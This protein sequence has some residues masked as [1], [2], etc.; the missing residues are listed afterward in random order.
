MDES[1]GTIGQQ[2]GHLF[3]F[4]YSHTMKAFLFGNFEEQLCFD[5]LSDDEVIEVL[6]EIN[7]SLGTNTKASFSQVDLKEDS[8]SCE[9]SSL[10]S[11]EKSKVTSIMIVKSPEDLEFKGK[12]WSSRCL[13]NECESQNYYALSGT[14][15]NRTYND[16]SSSVRIAKPSCAGQ[17]FLII[18]A[19][20]LRYATSSVLDFDGED[21]RLQ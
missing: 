2:P 18:H 14:V 12:K 1:V 10:T 13:Y 8:K 19:S 7:L 6:N 9:P 20:P 4:P 15:H 3:L 16:S 21:F 17:N 5:C 11:H